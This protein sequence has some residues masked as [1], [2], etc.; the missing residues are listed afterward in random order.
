[1]SNKALREGVLDITFDIIGSLLFA[2]GVQVFSSPNNIAPGG[3]TGLSVVLNYL[4]GVS[5]GLYVFVL[6]IPLLILALVFLGKRFTLKT[7][8]TVLI[9]SVLLDLSTYFIMPYYGDPILASLYAGVLQGAGLAIIFVRGGTTGGSDIAAK[10]LQLKSPGFSVGRLMLIVDAFVLAT[11]AIVYQ[12][13]ENALYGLIAIFAC[14]RIIDG[15]LYGLDTGKVLMVFSKEHERITKTV[16]QD[17]GRGCTRLKA[18][19]SYTGEDRPVL[20]CAVRKGEFTR[21]KQLVRSIDETAFVVALDASEIKGEGF[22][23]I[24]N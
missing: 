20:L 11:A 7:L 17:L 13:I 6:N 9:M 3:V 24:D 12:N 15:V 10:L 21:L 4:T 19:G 23:A 22:R 1:M 5:I 14:T 8:K 18:E 2:I 16:L